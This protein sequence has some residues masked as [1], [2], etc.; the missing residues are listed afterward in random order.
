MTPDGKSVVFQSVRALTGYDSEGLSEVFVYDAEA[1]GGLFCASCD[2][3][4]EAPAVTEVGGVRVKAAGYLPVGWSRT[5]QPR[6]ISDDGSRVF[7]DSFEPLVSGDP[8]G[9]QDVYEWERNGASACGEPQ[10]CQYLLSGGTSRSAS[11]LLDASA[12]GDSVFFVSDAR[13]VAQDDN[14]SDHLYDDRVDGV[15]PSSPAGCAGSECEEI[16]VAPPIFATPP[17]ATF[18]GVGNFPPV[19]KA[20]AKA[21]P[22]P[23]PKHK[24]KTKGK[25]AKGHG[26]RSRASRA[27]KRTG[28]AGGRRGRS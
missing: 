25:R 11:Y 4:G 1:G 19:A 15:Q 14:E 22:K 13:L 8:N 26:K 24:S 2:S 23:K 6:V 17:S 28:R 18:A 27:R 10:G 21:K 7:F 9:E 5:Y 16:P 3:S 20:P 12:N